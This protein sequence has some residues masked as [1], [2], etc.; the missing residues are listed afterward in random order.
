MFGAQQPLTAF[1]LVL[2]ASAWPLLSLAADRVV[3]LEHYTNFR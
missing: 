2:V 3:V 1:L